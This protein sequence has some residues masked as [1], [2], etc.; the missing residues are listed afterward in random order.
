MEQISKKLIT[1]SN[2]ANSPDKAIGI[3]KDTP[4]HNLLLKRRF[5]C[6]KL[7]ENPIDEQLFDA[8]KIIDKNITDYFFIINL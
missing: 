8:Y 5:I 7:K 3:F 6:R 1:I 2:I 4:I